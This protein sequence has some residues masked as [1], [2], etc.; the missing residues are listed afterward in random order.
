MIIR[1]ERQRENTEEWIA[2]FEQSIADLR[3]TPGPGDMLEPFTREILIR[4]QE[5]MLED[6]RGQVAEYEALRDGQIRRTQVESML[7]LGT[8]LVQARVAAGLTE[9]QLADRLRMDEDQ[10][11]RHEAMDYQTASLACLIEIAAVLRLQFSAEIHLPDQAA[12]DGG[13]EAT[14]ALPADS[15][16]VRVTAGE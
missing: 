14:A 15:V 13:P 2:K 16:T 7:D 6:L 8:A 12:D 9:R 10:L 1:N 4:S 11:K 3:A 5:S